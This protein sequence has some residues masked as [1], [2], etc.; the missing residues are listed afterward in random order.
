MAQV[1]RSAVINAPRAAVWRVIGGFQAL[2]DWHPAIAQSHKEL[3]DGVE[4]RRLILAEGGEMLEKSLG[5][6]E[7]SYGYAIVESPLPLS[8][9]RSVVSVAENDGKAVVTWSATFEPKSAQAEDIV[10]SIYSLGL[11]ALI[12]RF[13]D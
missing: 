10:A 2:P 1:T 13:G 9:Y 3:I 5:C 4:H 12:A 6:D 8:D 7:A 11:D